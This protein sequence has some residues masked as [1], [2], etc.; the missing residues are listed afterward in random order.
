MCA[1]G[2]AVSNR[3]EHSDSAG[4]AI[5]FW[6]LMSSC[7]DSFT[8]FI[9]FVLLYFIHD[10]TPRLRVEKRKAQK[11]ERPRRNALECEKM[12][13]TKSMS[14]G[15]AEPAGRLFYPPYLLFQY[16]EKALLSRSCTLGFFFFLF[17]SFQCMQQ[18]GR[19]VSRSA[20]FPLDLTSYLASFTSFYFIL[21]PFTFTLLGSRFFFLL[22]FFFS[23]LFSYLTRQIKEGG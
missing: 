5:D 1:A 23:T 19:K 10:W 12:D 22:L 8:T 17:L 20:R 11:R 14:L 4:E 16:I 18:V 2:H 21:S 7:V 15:T 6:F 13:K 3:Y 9:A